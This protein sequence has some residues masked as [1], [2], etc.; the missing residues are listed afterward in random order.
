MNN[1]QI[2][3][4][5]EYNRNNNNNKRVKKN[6]FIIYET[7]LHLS[8]RFLVVLKKHCEKKIRKKF[9][10]G[11]MIH[12]K[13]THTDVHSGFNVIASYTQTYF[14]FIHTIFISAVNKYYSCVLNSRH[15]QHTHRVN[16]YI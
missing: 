11:Y 13:H 16:L 14:F 10:F 3:F 2:G 12:T 6:Y 9:V 8:I 4:I 15:N 5:R 7:N 1:I